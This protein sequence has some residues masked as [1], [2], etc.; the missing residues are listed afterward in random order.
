[1]KWIFPVANH[2]LQDRLGK[3]NKECRW[4]EEWE[5]FVSESTEFL[6][7]KQLDGKWHRHLLIPSSHRR[8]YKEFLNLIA[9]NLQVKSPNI[10]A[11]S[12]MLSIA[13]RM[14]WLKHKLTGKPRKLVKHMV[15]STQNKTVYD[16][17]KLKKDLAFQF[18]PMEECIADVAKMFLKDL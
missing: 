1:M 12:W 8:Y 18:T 7:H 4:L 17:V 11:K 15:K 2:K 13:W 5:W 6:Y 9:E 16:N 10:E 3:W 14:D